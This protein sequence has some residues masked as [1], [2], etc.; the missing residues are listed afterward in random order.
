[1]KAQIAEG[2]LNNLCR[3]WRQIIHAKREIHSPKVKFT[4]APAPAIH[5]ELFDMYVTIG[6]EVISDKD[7]VGVFD[8]DATT[9]SV[10]TRDFLKKAQEGGRV[11][12]TSYELPKAFVV[13]KDKVYITQYNAQTVG[14]RFEQRAGR[15]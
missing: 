2:N 1:M 6:S 8:M 5:R 9:V 3:R 11:V 14:A 12:N 15:A 4:P 7:V 10:R 13:T